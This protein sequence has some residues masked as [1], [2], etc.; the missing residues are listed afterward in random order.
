MSEEPLLTAT[1]V[2]HRLSVARSWVYEHSNDLGVVRLGD[3]PRARLR[4]DPAIVAQLR[5]PRAG[6]AAGPN[7]PLLPISPS[8]RYTRRR[9]VQP[10]TT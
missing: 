1:E 7:T 6:A 8:R 4:F 5:L 3:G 2:A 9:R 10:R